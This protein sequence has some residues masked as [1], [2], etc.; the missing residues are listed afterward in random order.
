LLRIRL[1]RKLE[2]LPV[3]LL[4]QSDGHRDPDAMPSAVTR[5]LIADDHDLFRR[6]LARLLTTTGM[7][8]VGE[9]ADGETAVEFTL[10]LHPDV[11]VMDLHLPGI[12]GIEATRQ[13]V[14]AGIRTQIVVL[15]VS[16]EEAKVIDALVAG[17]C[18]YLLKDSDGEQIVAAIQA[19]TR[20]ENVISPRVAGKVLERLRRDPTLS[21]SQ[22]TRPKLSERELAVLQ[23][24]ACGFGNPEIAQLLF[25]SEN[26]VKNHVSSILTKLDVDNRVQATVRG[27]RDGLIEPP[28]PT[29]SRRSAV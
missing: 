1:E 9:A 8:V 26:T 15:T 6:G 12:S 20:N 27:I 2:V 18:G 7:D 19:A 4:D 16:A 10:R 28:S 29:S 17:A 11:V 24:I 13:I 5:V 23:L 21:G 22:S 14:E 3:D 25:I